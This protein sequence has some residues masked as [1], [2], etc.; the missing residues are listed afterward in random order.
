MC[1]CLFLNVSECSVWMGRLQPSSAMTPPSGH[2][3]LTSSLLMF[4]R[5]AGTCT[6]WQ[7]ADRLRQKRTRYCVHSMYMYM[8]IYMYMYMYMY[9]YILSIYLSSIN[10]VNIKLL[11]MHHSTSYQILCCMTCVVLIHIQYIILL[12]RLQTTTLLFAD[13]ISAE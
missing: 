1:S 7:K 9:M 6:R 3:N 5:C 12:I 2:I 10:K 8:Y 4:G 11:A 13:A